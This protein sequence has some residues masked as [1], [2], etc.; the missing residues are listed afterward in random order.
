MTGPFGQKENNMKKDGNNQT[1]AT[2]ARKAA[3]KEYYY[4]Q[5]GYTRTAKGR[6]FGKIT[7]PLDLDGREIPGFAGLIA[8]RDGHIF[9]AARGRMI[10][11]Y[12]VIS[13]GGHV[14]HNITVRG[15]DGRIYKSGI[16]R[17][18]CAAYHGTPPEPGLVADHINGD[19]QDNR[20][21]NLRWLTRQQNRDA[22]I[23]Y[24]KPRYT[25]DSPEKRMM[26]YLDRMHGDLDRAINLFMDAYIIKEDDVRC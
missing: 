15:D 22:S 26:R 13:D 1:K 7:P 23:A 4:Q 12:P 17:L 21:C 5:G 8:T 2:L 24:Q 9:D 14:Y 19:T 20:P 11:E 25:G 10:A 6:K 18:I 16:H 3:L